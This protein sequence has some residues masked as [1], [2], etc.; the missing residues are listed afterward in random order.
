MMSADMEPWGIYQGNP[1]MLIKQ[2]ALAA[3]QNVS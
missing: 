2:R 1:A 3:A